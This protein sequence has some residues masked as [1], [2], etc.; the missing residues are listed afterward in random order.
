VDHITAYDS[1]TS[2]VSE[3]T[4][5][6]DLIFREGGKA[7]DPERPPKSVVVIGTIFGSMRS[8]GVEA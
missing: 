3:A 4:S 1:A 2:M 7:V 8:Q 5:E 6:K